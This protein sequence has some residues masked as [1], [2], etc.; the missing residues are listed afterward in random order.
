MKK[1]FNKDRTRRYGLRI[2]DIVKCNNN[3]SIQFPG[4][5]EVVDFSFDNNS[6]CVLVNNKRITCVAEWLEIITKVEDT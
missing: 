2:G 5:G 3:H 4:T 6:V 1:T